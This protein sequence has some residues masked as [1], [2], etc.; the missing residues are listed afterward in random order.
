MDISIRKACADDA[1]YISELCKNGL[2]YD[3]RAE[4]VMDKLNKIDLNRE[5]V[6][7]AVFDDKVIGF[8]H[9]EKYDT[10]Y[11]E[12]LVNVL[13]IAA[14]VHY[15]RCGIGKKLI[16]AA[17][18]WAKE[19]GALAIRLN[20][21]ASRTQAHSFYRAVGFDSEKQQLRFLKKI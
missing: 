17:E 3:C 6:F 11:F 16:A 2:G 14:D 8:I 10:L 9:I 15:R 4:F 5:A 13:G 12:T 7:A 19:I 18:L 1:A 20:S 21:G